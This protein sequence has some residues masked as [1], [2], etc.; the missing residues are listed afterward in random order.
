MPDTANTDHSV[1]PLMPTHT[2]GERIRWNGNYAT[3]RATLYEHDKFLERKNLIQ[4]FLK[5]HIAML[6][7]G[8]I[9]VDSYNAVFF[10]EN[11]EKDPHD[12]HD[13]CPPTTARLKKYNNKLKSKDPKAATVASIDAAPPGFSDTYVLN[14]HLIAGENGKYLTSLE[15]LIEGTDDAEQLLEDAAG[16]GSKL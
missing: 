9:A 1:N 12:A 7:N 13:P 4:P 10:L 2:D 16:S 15:F 14:E 3:I 6:S 5:Q 11:P 8:K